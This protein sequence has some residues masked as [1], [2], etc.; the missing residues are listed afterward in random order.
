MYTPMFTQELAPALKNR[1]L[2]LGLSQVE[3]AQRAEVSRTTLSRLENGADTPF[4]T[5]V[6]DRL[7]RALDLHPRL[8]WSENAVRSAL[9]ERHRA[10]LEEQIHRAAMRERHLRLALD[11]A[12]RG[13][14]MK[15]HIAEARA[16]VALWQRNRTCSPFYIKRWGAILRLPPKQMAAEIAALGEWSDA[17]FQ[18]SPWSGAW[19]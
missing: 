11:L 1:R 3:L 19:S 8:S 16:Q 6:L 15:A 4:Q 7:V 12:T 10:R 13:A 2:A 5:D 14:E 17:L 9:D 18:N